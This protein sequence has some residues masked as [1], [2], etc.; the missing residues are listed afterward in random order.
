M[1]KFIIYWF[2]NKKYV[3]VEGNKDLDNS[4]SLWNMTW[5]VLK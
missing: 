1:Q 3:A 2:S 4:I 5:K